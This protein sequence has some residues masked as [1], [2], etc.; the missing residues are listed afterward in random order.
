MR[1]FIAVPLPLSV[2]QALTGLA[3]EL[4]RAWDKGAVRWIPADN[5]H[6][7]LRFLDRTDADLVG[8]LSRLLDESAAELGAFPLSLQ[9]TGAFPNPRRPRVIWAGISDF[10]QR[11][12]R[13]KKALDHRLCPLGWP[14]EKK[15]FRPHLTIGRVRRRGVPPTGPWLIK[16]PTL[17]FSAEAVQLVEST[18]KPAGA[19]YRVRHRARLARG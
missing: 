7:T 4:G 5:I 16:P 6:L 19:E 10:Q 17:E 13:L 18:L 15:P 14:P 9:G 12:L 1:A 11:L 3:T 8:E 2:R